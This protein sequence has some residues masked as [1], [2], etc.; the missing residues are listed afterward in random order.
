MGGLQYH[1]EFLI[2]SKKIKFYYFA[3]HPVPYHIGIYKELAKLESLEFCVIYEDDIGIRPTYVKEFKKII[4]WDINFLS[5]YP[6]EFMKNYSSKPHGGFLSRV[7]FSIFKK[8]L[9]DRPDV[10]LF[11]GYTSFSDWLIMLLAKATRT[12]IIFRGEATLRGTENN[13]VFKQQLKNFFLKKWLKMCDMVMYS[14]S[15]NKEYFKHYGV[16]ENVMLPIP[17]AVD[18]GF[19]QNERKKYIGKECGIKKELH[20]DEGDFVII[21]VSRMNGN[22]NLNALV[23]AVNKIEHKNINLFFG[24]IFPSVL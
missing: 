15:G 10:I 21:Y 2:M 12:K 14:C 4:K 3:P 1:I 23:E 13:P 8:I 16:N 11:K 5:G 24:I 9:V 18:N 20:I 22:K 17:C 7:N 6:H 19:F